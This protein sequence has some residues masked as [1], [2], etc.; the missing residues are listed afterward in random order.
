MQ[1]TINLTDDEIQAFKN[2][3]MQVKPPQLDDQSFHKQIFFH[4]IGAVNTQLAEMAKQS[5][6]DPETREKLKNSGIDVDS[7]EKE[8][9]GQ[10]TTQTGPSEP[11]ENPV[12]ETTDPAAPVQVLEDTPETVK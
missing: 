5:L 10:D 7:L 3:A 6:A 11:L 8:L 2:W 1:I 9:Y 4:G 12:A